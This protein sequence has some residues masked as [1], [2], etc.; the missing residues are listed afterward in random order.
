MC[1][2]GDN[3]YRQLDEVRCSVKLRPRKH[4][5]ASRCL[6]L[7]SVVAIVVSVVVIITTTTLLLLIQQLQD[8][9][10]GTFYSYGLIKSN[11]RANLYSIKRNSEYTFTNFT[12][13]ANKVL[14]DPE[15]VVSCYYDTPN[16]NDSNQLLPS[17]IHPHLCTHINVAFA[18]IVNKEISLEKCQYKAL[19]D[20]VKLKE[21]NPTLKILLSVGG[22]SNENGFSEMV[23]N[24]ASRK[25]FIK[26]VK[27]ILRNYSLDGIDLDWEFPAVS[28]NR[29]NGTHNR[30]RQH[31]SQLL[32]E[33]RSEYIREKRDYLLTVAV[34]APRT[35]VDIAYDVDQLDLYT[36][37]VNVMTYDFH[38]F[39]KYTPFTGLNSPLYSRHDE[40]LYM[41]TLNINYTVQ[42]YLSKGLNRNK[43]VVGIPTYGHSFTLVNTNNARVGS[44]ASGFGTLGGMGFVNY[45]DICLFVSSHR[46][47]VIKRDDE[48]KVPY[49]Y[50]GSEWVSYESP[51]SVAAKADFIRD[52]G[53]RGAMI[54]SLNAD[55]FGGVCSAQPGGNIKFPL[56]RSITNS[57][58]GSETDTMNDSREM[59]K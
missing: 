8:V 22:A 32:R 14:K 25:V 59:E 30:E 28:I 34:A 41:A 26:S 47:V 13:S 45:P 11:V 50:R 33:I 31:F 39:T 46:E 23:V 1:D 49:L 12:Y 37:Y 19:L 38:S 55:D 42:M 6:L 56:I 5:S 7:F 48:A 57:L 53:L 20:V 43:I 4:I 27:S 15:R 24:H 17:N 10:H 21:A 35:I 9:E 54:Y 29:G 36:D 16:P 2:Q 51:A 3:G 18:R 58:L 40:F 44:P 52:R